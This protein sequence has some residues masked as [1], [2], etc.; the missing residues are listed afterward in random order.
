[1]VY[2]I[3]LRDFSTYVHTYE[4]LIS[5]RLATGHNIRKQIQWKIVS[6]NNS[7]TP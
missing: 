1:M 4:C 3:Y 2:N 7:Q 6:L 5:I